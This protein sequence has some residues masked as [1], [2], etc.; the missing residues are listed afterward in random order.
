VRGTA[1]SPWQYVTGVVTVGA[2]GKAFTVTVISALG[3]SPP[4]VWLTQYEVLP[5]A[6]VRSR[7][8]CAAVP[9]VATVIT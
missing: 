2:S 3:L 9:P 7:S 4:I 5:D 8:S 1:I 6:A